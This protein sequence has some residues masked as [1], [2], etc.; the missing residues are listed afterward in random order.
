MNLQ[1]S[2]RRILR[3][4]LSEDI[5]YSDFDGIF[6]SLDV[7]VTNDG[8]LYV[9]WYDKDGNSIFSRNHWGRF[10]IHYCEPY[11]ELRFYSK[12]ISQT[13]EEFEETLIK[14]LNNKYQ[15]EFM[16]RPIKQ[17]SEADRYHCF[18]D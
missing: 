9:T 2:I 11:R 7:N 1:E 4:E 13:M 17:V 6:D 8:A 5:I 12:M 18:E 15:D 14:Y 3:E 10:F 16:S